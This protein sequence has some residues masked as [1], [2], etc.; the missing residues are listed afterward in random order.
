MVPPRYDSSRRRHLRQR[1]RLKK[2]APERLIERVNDIPR[3][4]YL[5]ARVTTKVSR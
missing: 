4:D 2:G 3:S 1:A 5:F